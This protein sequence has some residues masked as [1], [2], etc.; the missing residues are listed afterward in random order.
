MSDEVAD[1]SLGQ[2]ILSAVYRNQTPKKR[3]SQ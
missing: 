1:T 3:V 2:E